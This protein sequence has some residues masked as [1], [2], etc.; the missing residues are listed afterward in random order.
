M[1]ALVACLGLVGSATIG[2]KKDEPATPA[3]AMEEAGKKAGEA[4]EDA[5]DAME[6][7]G[8]KAGEAMEDAGDAV[9]DATN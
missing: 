6:K 9:E 2:C 3:E 8:E 4:M 5:G 7:A 1:F